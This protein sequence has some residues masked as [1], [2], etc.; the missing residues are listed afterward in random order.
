MFTALLCFVAVAVVV[1]SGVITVKTYK[2]LD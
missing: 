2:K 1:V